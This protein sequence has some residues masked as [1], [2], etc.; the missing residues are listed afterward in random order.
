MDYLFTTEIFMV[1]Q[2]ADVV[3]LVFAG[4]DIKKRVK[5]QTVPSDRRGGPALLSFFWRECTYF[6]SSGKILLEALCM[7]F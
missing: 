7:R 5:R 4:A 2:A 3:L 1:E 6:I